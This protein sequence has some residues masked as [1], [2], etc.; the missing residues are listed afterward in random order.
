MMKLSVINRSIKIMIL[1]LNMLL[2]TVSELSKVFYADIH[3]KK[4][5][6]D[7]PMFDSILVASDTVF[8]PVTS[9]GDSFARKTSSSLSL[10]E[11]IFINKD[12]LTTNHYDT[13]QFIYLGQRTN[14]D[15]R[16]YVA[17]SFDN[18]D[19]YPSE[20]KD[21]SVIKGN[22]RS[23]GEDLIDNDA[24]LLSKARGMMIFHSSTK[25]CSNCG[26]KTISYK[27]GTARKCTNNDCK[28]SHYPRIEPA[29][30]ML[31]LSKDKQHCLLGRKKEWIPGRYSTLAGFLEVGETVEMC[32]IRETLEESNVRVDPNT[33]KIIATQP[34]PFPSS[35]MVGFY[36]LAED[37]GL[38]AITI[39]ENEMEDIKWFSKSDVKNAL[40]SKGEND[41][42][43]FPGKS[44]LGRFLINKWCDDHQ[45]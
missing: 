9:K 18:E 8:V 40:L 3:F 43:N 30:I 21:A 11:P 27:S 19:Q 17:V 5:Q 34:W 36:A 16:H 20:L 45:F 12:K 42:L 41:S 44:S 6:I 39:D 29:A 10:L 37:D 13:S 28:K 4:M 32:M 33:V 22:L 2:L 31:V 14:I 38:P 24:A 35:L 1:L 7:S 26:S 25:Y 15:K 23:F